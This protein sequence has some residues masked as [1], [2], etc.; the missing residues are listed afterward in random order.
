MEVFTALEEPVRV[1]RKS[2][3]NA[4]K[5]YFSF[6][7]PPKEENFLKNNPDVMEIL[8]WVA[9]DIKT[10]LDE[11]ATVVLDLFDIFEDMENL[12][13]I[14]YTRVERERAKKYEDDFFEKKY[15]L[16]PEIVKKISLH[17]IPYE[18]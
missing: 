8:P 5:P 6:E 15:R 1:K 12:F 16:F 4:W 17:C 14:V 13:I 9:G 3:P 7:N 11:K 2:N 18:I 10:N